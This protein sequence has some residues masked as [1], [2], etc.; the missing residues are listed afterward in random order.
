MKRWHIKSILLSLLMLAMLISP[1]YGQ[2]HQL[3]DQKLLN[4]AKSLKI[5]AEAIENFK[6]E[7]NNNPS[8]DNEIFAKVLIYL[9]IAQSKLKK[10]KRS[11]PDAEE[12]DKR[13]K[14]YEQESGE[15]VLLANALYYSAH[16]LKEQESY[17]EAVDACG[18]IV[19]ITRKILENKDSKEWYNFEKAVSTL[20]NIIHI[21]EN[22]TNKDKKHT[23]VLADAWYWKAYALGELGK[24]NK[25]V[26]AFNK[27]IDLFS[28]T[29]KINEKKIWAW[30][31]KGWALS[32]LGRYNTAIECYDEALSLEK[33]KR[34]TLYI[35]GSNV[36]PE[37]K[38]STSLITVDNNSDWKDFLH[39]IQNTEKLTT[40]LLTSKLEAKQ[41]DI[42]TIDVEQ[43]ED[44]DKEYIVESFNDIQKKKAERIAYAFNSK[45]W[46]FGKLGRYKEAIE[47]L[48]KAIKI[49][50]DYSKAYNSKGWILLWQGKY[51]DAI[52]GFKKA[53]QANGTS[54]ITVD[55]ISD[56]NT[57]LLEI[58]EDTK[59]A[60]ILSTS[61]LKEA[62]QLEKIKAIEDVNQLT[63][64]MREGIVEAFNAIKDNPK[65]YKENKEEFIQNG[66]K[67]SLEVQKELNNLK[68]M[69]ILK[70]S[71]E[72]EKEEYDL[73]CSQ[74]EEIKWLNIAILKNYFTQN[75]SKNRKTFKW[76]WYGKAVA[77]NRQGGQ[78]KA[79]IDSILCKAGEPGKAS[80]IN[81]KGAILIE[82]NR[83]EDALLRLKKVRDLLK[84]S[85]VKSGN[86][87]PEKLNKIRA[88]IWN[89]I[90]VVKT[91]I[92]EDK[93]EVI[94]KRAVS[95]MNKAIKYDP[96][97][98]VYLNNLGD[99]Y[100]KLE[101]YDEAIK[102]YSKAIETKTRDKEPE[103]W[104]SH[105]G[106][107]KAFINLGD[108][109]DDDLKYEEALAGL[110]MINIFPMN[111]INN[112]KN[113]RNGKR[114]NDYYYRQGYTHVR[115]GEWEESR[116]D[117][118]YQQGYAHA[119]L[120]K[121]ED[122]KKYF[123]QCKDDPKAVRNYREIK[124]RLK[125]NRPA[126]LKFIGGLFISIISGILLILILVLFVF[127]RP[128]YT[129]N[130]LISEKMVIVLAPILLGFIAVGIF[131]PDIK[132]F[133]GPGGIGF[134]SETTITPEIV[135]NLEQ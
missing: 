27:A 72:L 97:N 94:L 54:L 127:D 105:L 65:F 33:H 109:F 38:D 81:D 100:L 21:L 12:A 68:K 70:E 62:N 119:K 86:L 4:K 131:L 71:G 116:N 24:Y 59:L 17:E 26:E 91:K 47:S 92:D 50:P 79:D 122:A 13:L 78:T 3:A 48:D 111:N 134:E 52:E 83:Y 25:A 133:T 118:Y 113:R 35:N 18:L 89:N 2:E 39:L 8:S 123:T 110:K 9:S 51:E 22:A 63:D 10:N 45:G 80:E 5:D 82:L 53:E 84:E 129:R 36:K 85:S 32:K 120:G 61:K 20:K 132:S 104:R 31:Y 77:T 60:K 101:S 66:I 57:L 76:I 19:D 29:N 40:K 58:Q 99:F 108:N 55:N 106:I 14:E 6:K 37:D 44:K 130:K 98:A 73:S 93:D 125:G 15:K 117:Y 69:E 30:N 95:D 41:L 34:Y 103:S 43:L 49:T 96:N 126:T 121:L 74:K 128:E 42:K 88:K 87:P 90:A 115:L 112:S 64:G 7:I 1:L 67:L 56:W 16:A 124:I 28:K 102:S 23:M 11:I 107:A 46:D 114:R 75:L 135:A